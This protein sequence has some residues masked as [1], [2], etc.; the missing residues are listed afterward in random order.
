MKNWLAYIE[1][2]LVAIVAAFVLKIFV[3][4]AIQVPT[5][6]MEPSILPGDAILVNK[7]MSKSSSVERA[8]FF[9]LQHVERG[10]VIVFR[11]PDDQSTKS[12]AI[13]FIKRCVGFAGDTVQIQ[14]GQ[15]F[16]NS[17]FIHSYANSSNNNFGPVVVPDKQLF[18]LG[19]NLEHSY[20][21]R[22]WGFVPE[23][24][25]IGKASWIYWSKNTST[26]QNGFTNALSSIRWN[27]I[28]TF[29][30]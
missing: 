2:T 15:L 21:S 25:I 20:D 1:V 11:F 30:R 24:N 26:Q 22:Y 13:T 7:F 5:A 18:V 6:S 14:N 19:D 23:D 12:T 8:G 28:G 29:V 27:R 9:S 16:V 17:T 10:D 3:V 4:E